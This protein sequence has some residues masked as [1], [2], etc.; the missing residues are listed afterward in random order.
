M[1][2]K[3]SRTTQ[4]NKTVYSIKGKAARYMGPE[5]QRRLMH[6]NNKKLFKMMEKIEE[7][8]GKTTDQ[9]DSSVLSSEEQMTATEDFTIKANTLFQHSS[10]NITGKRGS[11]N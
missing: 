3:N 6:F 4:Y 9:R 10:A 5:K 7:D 2:R 1:R 11:I 8:G